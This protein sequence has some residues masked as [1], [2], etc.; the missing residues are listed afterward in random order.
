MS[1]VAGKITAEQALLIV[2]RLCRKGG[3]VRDAIVAE[4]ISLL[5]EFTLDEIADEVFDAL[6][7]IDIQDCRDLAASRGGSRAATAEAVVDVIEE[8]LQPFFDQTER[9][10]DLALIAQEATYCMGVL[11]GIYRFE[12]ESEAEIKR[13]AGDLPRE[14]AGALLDD[15]RKRNTDKAGAEAMEGFVRERCPKWAGWVGK[16]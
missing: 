4:A 3:D 12:Q 16:E 6:D 1:D 2:E 5:S 8:E 14:Y 9:Y 11:A 7:L 15:W 10:H 13:L